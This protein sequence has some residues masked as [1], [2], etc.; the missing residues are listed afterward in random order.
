MQKS[1]WS[2]Q[3][4]KVNNLTGF[5]PADRSEREC[6]SC[7]QKGHYY[8]ECKNGEFLKMAEMLVEGLKIID[9]GRK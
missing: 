5:T 6:I 8:Y 3:D 1:D 9:N 4:I 7:G 2:E